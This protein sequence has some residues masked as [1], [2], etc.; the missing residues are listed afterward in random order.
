MKLLKKLLV[1]LGES[2]KHADRHIAIIHCN[3]FFD[4]KERKTLIFE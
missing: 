4:V 1:V 3:D 2:V